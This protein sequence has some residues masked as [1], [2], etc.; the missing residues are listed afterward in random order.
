LSNQRQVGIA[1]TRYHVENNGTLPHNVG[2]GAGGSPNNYAN[3]VLNARG[4]WAHAVGLG[5]DPIPGVGGEGED[6]VYDSIPAAG[7]GRKQ[8]LTNPAVYCPQL[9]GN[10]SQRYHDLVSLSGTSG[11]YQAYSD[12]VLNRNLGGVAEVGWGGTASGTPEVPTDDLLFADRMWMIEG[13]TNQG[14]WDGGATLPLRAYARMS[15]NTAQWE[16]SGFN[17]APFWWRASRSGLGHPNDVANVL[18]GDGHASGMVP[19]EMLGMGAAEFSH[20]AGFNWA[21][22]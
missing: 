13:V 5:G 16:P 12:Y 7:Y 3:G 21:R 2:R 10:A 22:R 1:A 18:Y 20:W 9:L 17:S 8:V 14:P 15:Q 6:E 19:S 4:G 11:N